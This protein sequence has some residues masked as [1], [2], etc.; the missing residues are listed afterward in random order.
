MLTQFQ[1]GNPR[2][3]RAHWRVLVN[4]RIAILIRLHDNRASNSLGYMCPHVTGATR[5]HP[6]RRRA[7]AHFR[8]SGPMAVPNTPVRYISRKSTSTSAEEP[9]GSWIRN[10]HK[11]SFS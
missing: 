5:L 7:L 10:Q 6:D 11:G 3:P 4:G 2:T 1:R 9:C 8:S